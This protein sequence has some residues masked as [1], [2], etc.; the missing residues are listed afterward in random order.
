M[1]FR[2]CLCLLIVLFINYCGSI[3]HGQNLIWAQTPTKRFSVSRLV[4]I[5][6]DP[7]EWV[8]TG[9]VKV[10]HI[11]A[12]HSGW[13]FKA[14]A[15]QYS[16]QTLYWSE[17]MNK[18][19]QGLVL[20]GTT[21][22][23]KMVSGVSPD[24]EGLAVDWISNNLYWTD[25]LFNWIKMAPL[26][27]N[28]SSYK[29]IV[30]DGLDNPHGIAVH[31][32]KGYLIW[33]DWGERPRIELADLLGQNRRILVDTDIYHPRG[34]VIDYKENRLFWVD[35]KKDTIESVAFNGMDRKTI[36]TQDG[37]NFY[38]IAQYDKYVFVTEQ[39]KGH[40]KIFDKNT[41][42]NYISYK[43]TYIPYAII[44]YDEGSQV[45]DSSECDDFSCDQICVN[46]PIAGPSCLCGDGFSTTDDGKTCDAEMKFSMPSHVYAISDA[47]CQYPANLAYIS[48]TNVT[49]DNQCYLDDRRG[50]LALTFDA[51]NHNLYFS[52]NNTKT[53][54]R[55]RLE[56]G[57][58]ATT[59][60][61]GTGVVRGL[62][63]D[64]I[65][66][67]LYWTDSTFKV[68]KVA[69]KDGTFQKIVI[70]TDLKSPLGI[71]VHPKR[72]QIYWTDTGSSPKVE[73]SFMDGSNRTLIMDSK[74][75]GSPNHI[76]ID[77]VKD[78]LYW[79]DSVLNHVRCY[80]LI[81]GRITVFFSLE[82]S[83]FY[84]ISIFKDFLLWTDTDSMNG[85]HVA[86]IDQKK[87][88]RGIIHPADGIA[89][90]LI[91]YDEQNQPL[92]NENTTDTSPCQFENNECQQLCLRGPN[93]TYYCECGLGYSLDDNM[94]TCSSTV[95][96]NNFLIVTDAYQKQIYQIGT[97][98][99]VVH[100]IDMTIRHQP[101]AVD[102]DPIR[103]RV[104]WSDNT[105]RII[106]GANLD[107]KFPDLVAGLSEKSVADGL[108][109]DF[110]NRLLYYTDTGLDTINVISLDDYQQKV[111]LFSKDL[112]EPRAIVVLPND[113]TMYWT[114]W[115][116]NPKIET[117]EMDGTNRET[118]LLLEKDSWP[119]GLTVDRKE[120]VLYWADAKYN[121]IE[122]V[123]IND[124]T[125]RRVILQQT[126]NAH[127]FGL[128]IMGS[129]LYITDWKKTYIS[130]ISKDGGT[131]EQFGPK[132]FT[133]LYGIYGYNSSELVRGNSMCLNNN[134][135]HLCLPKP[136]GYH[137]CR[138]RTGFVLNNDLQTCTIESNTTST[139]TTS[140]TP[141]SKSSTRK[142]SIINTSTLPSTT[143]T[144]TTTTTTFT[145]ST[146]YSKRIISTSTS[147]PKQVSTEV[148]PSI[149]TVSGYNDGGGLPTGSI[150]A[151]VIFVIIALIIV[152]VIGVVAYRKYYSYNIPHGR[153][154]ED[155]KVNHFYRI[156]YPDN[157]KDEL[158]I[159]SGIE[160]PTFDCFNDEEERNKTTF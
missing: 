50:Y 47:I 92:F 135:E 77:F 15:Y 133:R 124:Q 54:S 32:H 121:K 97:T 129:Y 41:G 12:P 151:I 118:F 24:V 100:A 128:A 46:D 69:R 106:K 119:N 19:I 125:T 131:L 20:N 5:E 147:F 91:T 74:N 159:D 141:S 144:T 35:S 18:H 78:R 28:V 36:V 130:R 160:N 67:N 45:G 4:G 70:S 114:D 149:T 71:A 56:L 103:L 120:K 148:M 53:I 22:T 63:L 68:I 21:D 112:D 150:V 138:C 156:T 152:I 31:P 127:Y 105:A 25:S 137:A 99:G 126:E 7:A 145:P 108:A 61:G 102:F 82:K 59:I 90:D 122:S 60:I 87:K 6:G 75:L 23:N 116:F 96:R 155:T 16:T 42:N 66:G 142:S 139:P 57:S 79:S 115:G 9:T 65:A 13:E 153:L 64:W 76:F 34:V 95:I 62:A 38:A 85:L 40:L 17:S 81:T 143:T 84:G 52:A 110:I 101:I 117:A 3:R 88:I 132:Q 93:M 98:N 157:N 113:G 27:S 136:N 123:S 58:N 134:C 83:K 29:I 104:Y 43:L 55:V 86:R 146:T 51:R 8:T 49:L 14:L 111:V 107:G 26:K 30:Q 2:W 140:F 1:D 44:M 73:K 48:L 33:T 39:S 94:K 11:S 37:S 154:V 89:A 10:H 80:D 109:V 72:G 158:T